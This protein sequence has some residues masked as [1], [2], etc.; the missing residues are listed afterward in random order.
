MLDLHIRQKIRF[1]ALYY[2][3]TWEMHKSSVFIKQWV[4]E[5]NVDFGCKRAIGSMTNNKDK[6][7]EELLFGVG[8]SSRF[9]F[10]RAT[11]AGSRFRSCAFGQK[12]DQ[13]LK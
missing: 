5:R 8:P 13:S 12:W 9:R 2:L 11:E 7:I 10:L 6:K 4:S 1:F 3:K